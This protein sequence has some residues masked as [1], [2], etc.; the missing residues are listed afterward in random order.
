VIEL[1]RLLPLILFAKIAAFSGIAGATESEVAATGEYQKLCGVCHL[2]DGRGIPGVYPPLNQ[3]LGQWA[4]E[5]GGRTYLVKIVTQGMGGTIIVDGQRYSGYM[6]GVGMRLDPESLAVL[7]N[8][9][10]LEFA[11]EVDVQPFTGREIERIRSIEV[12]NTR[13]LRP[14]APS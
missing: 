7:L 8:Y 5:E 12:K 6:P 14:Q 1:R 4:N 9:V 2:P 3:R 13:N 11:P 10:L